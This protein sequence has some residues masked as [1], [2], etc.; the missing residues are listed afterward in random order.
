MKVES[1]IS[2]SLVITTYNWPEALELVLISVLG[3]IKL[4]N[5]I[6]IADD[7]SDQRTSNIVSKFGKISSIPIKHSWQ[8]DK[9][10][11]A[12][13][14]RNKAISKSQFDYIV[15]IDG[16]TIL[17]P[18]FI[19]DHINNAS[20][21]CF[22]QGSR[23]LLNGRST[24]VSIATKKTYFSFF[25]KGLDNRKN[26]IHSNLMS[27]IFSSKRNY[28]SGIKTCNMAFY[29]RDCINVN[30]FNES[31]IGW[32]KEDS[33][34]AIRLMNYGLAR[35]T[36]RYNSIQYHLWHNQSSRENLEKNINL[37]KSIIDSRESWCKFGINQYL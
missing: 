22:V 26:A 3:Q 2:C 27:K 21:G 30:G 36:I 19:Q 25:D 28:I 34:F 5:E 14:S 6:I 20:K 32:G 17:H 1:K 4:P 29:K 9:G 37:L 13:K 8:K 7:G 10:F 12:A 31:F 15:L 18:L 33:E 35:K 23:V 24:A 11:R 16:D